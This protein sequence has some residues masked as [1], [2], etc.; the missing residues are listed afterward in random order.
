SL[1][2]VGL[3][4]V[5]AITATEIRKRLSEK[6]IRLLVV[7]NALARQAF[8]TCGLDVACDLLDGPCALAYG[9]DNVVSTVREL[10]DIKKEQAN[11]LVV[12]AAVMDGEPFGS[13][14]IEALSK[15]PTRDEAIGTIVSCALAPGMKAAAC[16]LAPGSKIAALV[17]A[18]EESHEGEAAE[19]EP[20]AEAPAEEAPAE[21]APAEE[22][23][24]E[25]VPAE[26]A[27]AEE[28]PA[29]EAPA[30]EAPAEEAPTEEAPAEEA[31]ADE[32]NGEKSSSDDQ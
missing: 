25:E 16:I 14:R 19:E 17:K 28:A 8:K 5:N 1:A 15:F 4:G 7:K 10:L 23:P 21:E 31:P 2:I 30:E 6:E 9:G 26:E 20:A 11:A 24:A 27:P 32:E 12:K 3:T 18:I 29:E 13:D 22:A